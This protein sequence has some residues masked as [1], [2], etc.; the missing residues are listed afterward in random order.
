[1]ID[2]N[3]VKQVAKEHFIN[4]NTSGA[5]SM[6]VSVLNALYPTKDRT[7]KSRRID[8]ISQVLETV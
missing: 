8:L 4:L 3:Q 6:L 7:E 2:K 1:M 5:M